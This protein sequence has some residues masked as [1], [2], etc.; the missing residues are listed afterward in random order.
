[1]IKGKREPYAAGDARHFLQ[2]VFDGARISRFAPDY[3]MSRG[4][5]MGEHRRMHSKDTLLDAARITIARA[6]RLRFP[7]G[8]ER[9]RHLEWLARLG[10]DN[11]AP[12]P[13][14]GEPARPAAEE[15]PGPR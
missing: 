2:A 3:R 11:P 6:I 5:A 9:D 7:S 8:P 4:S 12:L 10:P 1:M 13:S 15:P 14:G